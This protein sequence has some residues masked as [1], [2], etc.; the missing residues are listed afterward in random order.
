[1]TPFLSQPVARLLAN[2]PLD[3]QKKAVLALEWLERAYLTGETLRRAQVVQPGPGAS[4]QAPG[5][6]P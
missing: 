4:F 2:P 5:D 3:I 6:R 1:M